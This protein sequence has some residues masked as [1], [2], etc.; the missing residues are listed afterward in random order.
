MEKVSAILL[1]WKRPDNIPLIV[2]SLRQHDFFDDIVI[3]DNSGEKFKRQRDVVVVQQR[4]LDDCAI[5]NMKTF[6]RYCALASAK[7]EI[8]WI[9]D[10]DITVNNIP[11]LYERFIDG[12]SIV[13]GLSPGHYQHEAHKKPW[14]NIGWGSFHRR[15]WFDVVKQW[16]EKYGE[17]DLLLSKFDRI[18]TVLY[19]HHDPVPGNYAPIINAAG[20]DS[21]HDQHALWKQKDHYKLRDEAVRKALEVRDEF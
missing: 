5:C 16:I 21:E 8:A 9:Q 15:Q 6:G 3:H 4:S 11:E 13:A 18:Y 1:N 14:L 12:D 10:D 20:K 17:D 2:E 19:P 7:H